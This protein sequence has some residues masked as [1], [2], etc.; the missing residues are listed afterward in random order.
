MQVPSSP[1]I[2][3]ILTVRPVENALGI[4]S[5]SFRIWREGTEKGTILVPRYCGLGGPT[6][7]S[8]SIGA[9]A[10]INFRG[11]LRPHQD[12]AVAK[13]LEAFGSVGGGVLSLDVGLGKTV[14]ALALAARLGRRTMIVV[15]KGFLADQ[16]IER[17]RQFC[18]GATIGRVQQDTFDVEGKDFILAMIQT[19]CVRPWPPGAFDSVG[20]LV[21]D[22]A[23]HIAAEAFSQ[24]MF[25]LGPRYTLGLTATPERKDGLTRV[26]YW[27]LGPEFFRLQ[28]TAQEQVVVHRVPFTCAAFRDPP[29]VTNFGKLNFAELINVLTRL[30]ERNALLVETVTKSPGK[31]ILVLTDRREHALWLHA[32]L[33]NSALYLG[34]MKQEALEKSSRARIVVGTFSLAQEGLDIPTLDTIFL[35]TPHSDVKQ[36]IGRIMRGASRP[37]IWDVVDSWSV[38]YSMWRKRLATYRS[39]GVSLAEEDREEKVIRGKC[40]L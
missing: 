5:P 15:H 40:L 11:D 38:L 22:E 32:H 28:R 9:P 18:P 10:R 6:P 16:W 24:S 36:A 33:E 23:H 12:E 17:I 3:K 37:V 27:F 20:L 21:V 13:G 25:L 19:L 26:L 34:G 35:A 39:L 1:E 14:C 4:Q 8:G 30:P 31:H 7:P 2:K 29:P